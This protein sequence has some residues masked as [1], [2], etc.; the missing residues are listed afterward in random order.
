MR[1]FCRRLW[2]V[3]GQCPVRFSRHGEISVAERAH[4]RK[5]NVTIAVTMRDCSETLWYMRR[6]PMLKILVKFDTVKF[7]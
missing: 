4:L 2:A 1:A 5:P 7:D 6:T 3:A